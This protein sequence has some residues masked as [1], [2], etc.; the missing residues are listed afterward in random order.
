MPLRQVSQANTKD[1][2]RLSGDPPAQGVAAAHVSVQTES[3]KKAISVV[4][5]EL[6]R[7]LAR[8]LRA[9]RR[10]GYSLPEVLIGALLMA[11][12]V[13]FLWRRFSGH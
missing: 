3:A 4:A 11:I 8:S 7:Y 5:E 12:L 9:E 6:G 1:V 13:T 10:K 2:A